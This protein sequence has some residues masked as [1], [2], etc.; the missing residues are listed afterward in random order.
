MKDDLFV[1]MVLDAWNAKISRFNKLLSAF[2]DEQLQKEVA[3]G[4]NTGVYLLGHLTAINNRLIPLF[5]LGNELNPELFKTFVDTPEKEIK[6]KPSVSELRKDW[7]KVNETLDKLFSRMTTEEWFQKHASVSDEDF[8]KQP[9][10]NK[11]N[12]I[13]SRTNHLDYHL[14]Q[15]ILL[16]PGVSVE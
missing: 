9:H 16:Q 7:N 2:S 13:I 1:K 3:P 15:L 14:G 5:G 10:R 6:E 8:A 12:V 11:L 4:K